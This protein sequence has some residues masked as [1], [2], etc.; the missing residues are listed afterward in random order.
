[1]LGD[2]PRL[3]FG[4]GVVHRRI[5]ATEASD[6]RVDHVPHILLKAYVCTE[7]LGSPPS[8]RSSATKRRPSSSWRPDTTTRRA[9]LRER[10]RRCAP[11]TCQGAGDQNNR[12][13]HEI[14]LDVG[15]VQRADS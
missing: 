14:L 15:S 2:R 5:E 6:G 4:S 1:L 11:D 9:I 7:E 8:S 10:H 13:L 12:G 3:A